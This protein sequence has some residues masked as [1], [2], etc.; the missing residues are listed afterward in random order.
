MWPHDNVKL[1][2]GEVLPLWG[3]LK[4]VHVGGHFAGA[5]VCLWEG[6][7]SGK[8]VLL[9]GDILQASLCPQGYRDSI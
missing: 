5:Q 7:A 4:I 6:G 1:W 2:E 3:G 8:G 9:T